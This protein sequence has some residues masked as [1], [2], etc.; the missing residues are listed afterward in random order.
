[1]EKIEI[2]SDNIEDEL[3]DAEKYARLALDCK[4]EDPA[5]AELYYQ[6]ANEEIGHMNKLHDRVVSIINEYR[7]TNGDP[8]EAMKQ[9]YNMLH[10]RHISHL[11]S[12]K[13]ILGT[14]K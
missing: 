12:T 14:Y 3:Q 13:G 7:K 4:D 8:P 11:A 1:M 6:L 5:T 2:L 9:V 10:K